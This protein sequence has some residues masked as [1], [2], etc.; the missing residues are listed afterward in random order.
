MIVEQ[1]L[2]LPGWLYIDQK[3]GFGIPV[4]YA[5]ELKVFVNGT[6]D[7]R[8]AYELVSHDNWYNPFQ[9]RKFCDFLILIENISDDVRLL[10]AI[11]EVQKF[12]ADNNLNDKGY[13]N[14]KDTFN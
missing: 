2:T 4:E 10:D 8:I 6:A 3:D 12:V 9:G 5:F 13:G 7:C 14:P 1:L 11:A